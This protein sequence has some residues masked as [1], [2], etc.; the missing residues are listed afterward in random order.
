MI[1]NNV[2]SSESYFSRD[3]VIFI[4]VLCICLNLISNNN[5]IVNKS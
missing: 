1:D 4:D 5:D 3:F 2:K